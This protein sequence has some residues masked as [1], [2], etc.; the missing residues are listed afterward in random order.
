VE[1][2]G[3]LECPHY[4]RPATFRDWAIP[5]ILNSGNHEEIR[6]WRRRAALAKTLRNRPEL[7]VRAGLTNEEISWLEEL[8]A[9]TSGQASKSASK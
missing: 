5:E 7:L 1:R 9:A 4:T 8:N 6:R 2:G 3:I